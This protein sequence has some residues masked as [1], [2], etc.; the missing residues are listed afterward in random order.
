MSTVI[1][2][3]IVVATGCLS[4]ALGMAIYAALTGHF[5]RGRRR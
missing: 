4:A 1:D 5:R 2:I 3:L